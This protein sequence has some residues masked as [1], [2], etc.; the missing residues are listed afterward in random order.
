MSVKQKKMIIAIG[1]AVVAIAI[2][3]GAPYLSL[4]IR[5]VHAWHS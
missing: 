5:N 3:I 4:N 1:V 2:V